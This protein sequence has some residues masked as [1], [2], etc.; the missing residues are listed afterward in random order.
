MMKHFLA[1][2]F[3]FSIHLPTKV[4]SQEAREYKITDKGYGITWDGTY[5]YYLDSER[6]ALIRFNEI[7]G[8]EIFNIGLAN[9]KGI[10]FDPKEGR[11]LVTAP[12]VILKLDPNTGGVVDRIPVP[13]THL[14]GIASADGL[15]YLLDLETGKVHFFDKASSMIV[16]GFLTDRSQPRDL[17]YGK[18]SIWISDSSNGTIYRYNPSN[19]NITGSV[20][21]P[22]NEMRGVL[23]SGSKLWVVDRASQ[24]IR[25]ISFVE[26]D[27]FLASGEADYDITYKLSY[28]LP[29]VSLA[30]AEIAILAPPTTEKQR[31]RNL[32]S[33]DKAF[34]NGALNRFRSFNKKL[35]VDSKR[36]NQNTEIKMQLRVSN[37]VYYVDDAFLQKN[38]SIPEELDI[39]RNTNSNIANLSPKDNLKRLNQYYSLPDLASVQKKLYQAGFPVRTSKIV[40]IK[41]NFTAS[42]RSTLETYLP[43]FGW[44]PYTPVHQPLNPDNRIFISNDREVTLFQSISSGELDSPVYFRSSPDSEWENLKSTWDIVINKK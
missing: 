19:G 4:F 22:A 3:L 20:Q 32:T 23:F 33:T 39:L 7:G 11:I 37:M 25:N 35:T 41:S 27:R 8:Q 38:E 16:G 42:E 34:R 43:G 44:I 10:S 15:Y 31:L 21:A 2:A 12:R 6:R 13:I 28:T 36:G 29:N 5:L 30:K 17:T 40:D 18:N 24:E 26:T 1:I 9:M 14:A